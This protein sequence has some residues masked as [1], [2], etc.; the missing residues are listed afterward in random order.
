[1][2]LIALIF[3]AVLSILKKKNHLLTKAEELQ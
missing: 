2:S 3:I 1:M